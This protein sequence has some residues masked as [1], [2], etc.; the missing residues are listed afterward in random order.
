LGQRQMDAEQGLRDDPGSV[1]E[2]ARALRSGETTSR[3]AVER[4]LARIMAVDGIVRAWISVQA[5]EARAA[6]DVLDAEARAGRWRGPLHGVPFAVKDVIDL[7]GQPTRAG[8]A[9]RA[10]AAPAA[11][12]ATVVLRLRAQGAIPL[13]KVHTT[14]FAYF[15]GVPPTRNPHDPRCTP[16]GSSAGS[17]AAVASGT[18]PF[19]IGTQTAASVNRPASFCGIGAFKPSGLSVV[20]AGVTPFAPSFDTLGAFAA[21][22]ADAAEVVAAMA[23]EAV[24]RDCPDDLW[25][26]EVVMID[27]PYLAG[28]VM[29]QMQEAVAQL[30]R[31]LAAA[32]L[33]VR[34]ATSP[35]P[36]EGLIAAHRTIMLFEFSRI[37]A[38]LLAREEL[39]GPRFAADIR[40]GLAVPAA[41]HAD[42]TNRLIAARRQFWAH[43]GRRALILAPAAP[44][45]A[46]E[47]FGTGDPT[48]VAPLTALEG[49]IASIPAGNCPDTGLPLG[50]VL[51][52]APGEDGPLAATLRKL[53]L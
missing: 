19:A 9:A 6:A 34:R 31:R 14:E 48:I 30:G 40:V 46:P 29:P 50:A 39:I 3:A 1:A 18:V 24:F 13:G 21:T 25:P 7:E 52:A 38:G 22:A 20:G 44:G 5:E 27:D 2:I 4:A 41:E 17:V 33:P 49:P 32:G 53:G 10:D 28:R 43:F 11:I 15:D 12:D 23:P 51:A 16:G 26:T 37:H 8:S 36:F 45:P 35:V 42:A 47:G